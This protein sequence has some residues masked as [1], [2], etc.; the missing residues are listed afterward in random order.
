[1]LLIQVIGV[2]HG[3]SSYTKL[4]RETK[5]GESSKIVATNL[6]RIPQTGKASGKNYVFL[7]NQT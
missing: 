7:K 3:S 6:I 2:L 4:E 1:M 5:N